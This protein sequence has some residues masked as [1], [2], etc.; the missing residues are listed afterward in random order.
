MHDPLSIMERG[1]LEYTQS[2]LN[3]FKMIVEEFVL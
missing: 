3:L 1:H 2:V